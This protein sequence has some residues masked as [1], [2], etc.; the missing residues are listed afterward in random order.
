[1]LLSAVDNLN[2]A[3]L[4]LSTVA[5]SNKLFLKHGNAPIFEGY[6]LKQTI[7]LLVTVHEAISTVAAYRMQYGDDWLVAQGLDF[8]LDI[9]EIFVANYEHLLLRLQAELAQALTRK[10]LEELLRGGHDKRQRKLL[11]WFSEFAEKPHPLSTSFP[12]TIKPSLAVLWG[13][14]WM[15]YDRESNQPDARAG[16]RVRRDRV[17][18]HIDFRSTVQ[19]NAPASSDCK[20]KFS[21]CCLLFLKSVSVLSLVDVNFGLELIGA[22]PQHQA[23]QQ[24]QDNVNVGLEELFQARNTESWV[25]DLSPSSDFRLPSHEEVRAIGSSRYG[26]APPQIPGR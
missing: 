11:S 4:A 12:W 13:V 19:W 18:Q 17:L 6:S 8:G 1:M 16:D 23:Q 14:C 26:Q 3:E 25:T 10:A 20:F 2:P 15:F 22:L 24:P 9:D 7:Q 5:G 21:W